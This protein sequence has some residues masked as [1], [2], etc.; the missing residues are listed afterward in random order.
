MFTFRPNRHWRCLS[1]AWALFAALAPADLP[2]A[3][4][5]AHVHGAASLRVVVDGAT[6]EVALESPLDSLLGFERSPRT[7]A[8]RAAVRAM[9]ARL[10]QPATLFTPTP[11]ARCVAGSVDIAS[12][13]L[14]AELLGN[15]K[16]AP[17][18]GGATADE[19]ADLDATFR[20]RCDAPAELKGMDVA[21]LQA[22]PG[23][24]SVK[25]QVVGPRGQ[26]ATTLSGASRSLR[27]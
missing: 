11:A 5:H 7:E 23:L 18:T 12:A 14:P 26:S 22:F 27:W 16:P 8:E 20:W 17:G 21:L 9:A 6:L 19:H 2:A 24:R 1:A 4:G 25:V 15:P 3:Q 13:A 10:R